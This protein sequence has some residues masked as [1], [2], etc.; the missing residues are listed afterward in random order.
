MHKTK[1]KEP[2]YPFVLTEILL[3]VAPV[4]LI[5][6][7]GT[8][9]YQSI[10]EAKNSVFLLVFGGYLLLMLLFTLEML[11]VRRIKLISPKKLWCRA[12]GVQRLIFVFWVATI[13]SAVLSPY[14]PYTLTGMSRNEG[15][16]TISIYCGC[17]LCV[18]SFAKRKPYLIWVLGAVMTVL[19]G[20]CLLQ[21]QGLNPLG[22]YPAGYNYFDADVAYLGSYLGTIGNAGLT[23]ALLCLMLPLFWVLLLRLSGKLKLLLIIP[24]VLCLI[25]LIQMNVQAGIMA[26]LVG[27]PVTLATVFPI[28]KG[29]RKWLWGGVAV[30]FFAGFCW[31]YFGQHTAGAIYEL[32]EIL[33]GN[34]DPFFGSGRIHAWKNILAR[35]PRR[36]LLGTGPDTMLA[37]QIT[38]GSN[39]VDVAHNEYLNILYHQGFFGFI[40]YLTALVLSA[41]K[42]LRKSPERALAAALGGGVLYYSIQAFFSFSMC[43][44]AGLFWLIWAL[45]ERAAH[46]EVTS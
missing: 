10:Q 20:I 38:L 19:C 35:V 11:L 16:L 37:A 21:L 3:C 46:K 18:S 44:S 36:P 41:I 31:V 27:T 5:L 26:L 4:L 13:L 12:S 33:H 15:L 29:R 32:H 42:W 34:W 8:G 40:P 28:N 43:Q 24:T 14:F 45:L 30:L 17:F 39:P 6:Y 25:V 9:G 2:K 22:L 7:P 1:T 23:A